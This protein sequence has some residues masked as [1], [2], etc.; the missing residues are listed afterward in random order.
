MSISLSIVETN[1]QIEGMINRS[2]SESI[3][4]KLKSNSKRVIN[5]IKSMIPTWIQ[6]QQEVMSLISDGVP[7]SLNAQFGLVPGQSI[8]AAAAIINAI[9]ESIVVDIPSIKSDLKG[10][11]LFKIQPEDFN[12]LLNLSEGYVQTLSRNLHWLDWLLTMGGTAIVTGYEYQPSND[13]RSGGGTMV[14]GNVWR[15]P[16]AYSGTID[17]NFVTRALSNRETQISDA[18]KELFK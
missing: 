10:Q 8:T 2:I 17:N 13:G 6:E 1:R 9:S 15:V 11:I 4:K 12:N 18:L 14:S 5:R 7:G 3:N 16:S